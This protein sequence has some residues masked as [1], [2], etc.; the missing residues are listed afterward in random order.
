MEYTTQ[1]VARS[2]AAIAAMYLTAGQLELHPYMVELLGICAP[3][4]F[5]RGAA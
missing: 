4:E 5:R 1:Y 3:T 2:F